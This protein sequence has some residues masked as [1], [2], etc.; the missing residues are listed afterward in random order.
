MSAH[1]SQR[2]QW[3]DHETWVQLLRSWEM[4]RGWWA[5]AE[6][7]LSEWVRLLWSVMFEDIGAGVGD[8]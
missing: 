6:D 5:I 3:A 4:L 1:A 7:Q 2:A 8:D